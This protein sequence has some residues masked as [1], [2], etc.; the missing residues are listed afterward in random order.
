MRNTLLDEKFEQTG[1]SEEH[2][3]SFELNEIQRSYFKLKEVAEIATKDQNGHPIIT[4]S[5][6]YVSPCGT[7]RSIA[8]SYED[9]QTGQSH[10]LSYLCSVI[11]GWAL[12]D[13]FGG[14]IATPSGSNA[15]AYAVDKLSNNYNRYVPNL[16]TPEAKP[17]RYRK[18]SDRWKPK[19]KPSVSFVQQS[20]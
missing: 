11:F 18:A 10:D 15:E 7:V 14:V 19:A 8:L 16:P 12:D 6:R 2:R 4:T 5:L 13:K 9:Q 3:L 1:H 17:D 20:Q